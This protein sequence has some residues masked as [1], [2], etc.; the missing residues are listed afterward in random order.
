MVVVYIMGGTG[1]QFFQYAAGRRL[2]H[3]W[4]TELKLDL[5]FY[6]Q[7]NLRPYTLNLFNVQ[8]NIATAEEIQRLKKLEETFDTFMP[9][10]LDCPDNVW[11]KGYWG[12]EKYFADIADI[13]RR[14][15]TLK[16]PL[17]ESARHWKE[18]ILSCECSVSMH[19]RHGDFIYSPI[20]VS[21]K[22]EK[23]FAVPPPDYYYNCVEILKREN[24]NLTVFVFSDNLKWCKE[25]LRL[26][27]PTEFVEGDGLQD[28]EELYLMSLC[29]HNIIPKSTF[30]WWAAWLN[31]NPD[32]KV[33]TP[34]SA[35]VVDTKSAASSLDT[36]KWI[37]IPFKNNFQ[38]A[39]KL[40]PWF[41]LLMVVN[42]DAAT[43]AES[44]NSIF[45]QN[46]RH[47]ELIIVDNASS[48]GSGKILQQAAKTFDNI[49]L[50]KLH[51]KISNGAAWNIALNAAQG[52]DVIFLKGNDR[53]LANGL[54][55]VYLTNEHIAADI[56]NSVAYLKADESGDVDI[57][58]KKFFL[59]KMQAFQ[60]MNGIF[61]EKLDKFLLLKIL[62]NDE[63]FFPIAAR[64][65]KRKFL[66][67]NKIRFNEKIGDDAEKLFALD[68]MFQTDKII[69]ISPTFYIAP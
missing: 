1:N 32:K 39:V 3:K 49:T 62:A 27:V 20:N 4:N 47:F 52:Y 17:S 46:Y 45:A 10:V 35:S 33:F 63:K 24:K 50:I 60:N 29:K 18:K 26:D 56:V 51:S 59:K 12:N 31:Q 34:V 38:A 64:A 42:N 69:F 16:N 61:R 54:A 22:M 65:F 55:S 11:L 15:F 28:V 5:S 23:F 43:L 21:P 14:E 37:E 66:E 8:E 30:S 67:E 6:E 53:L 36:D 9:E 13:L 44:L 41:S 58:G 2:A 40:R 19:F 25:N 7:D 68:A 57:A 48:D